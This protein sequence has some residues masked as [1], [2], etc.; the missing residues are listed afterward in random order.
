LGAT[1]QQIERERARAHEE[2]FKTAVDT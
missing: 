2:L 1:P